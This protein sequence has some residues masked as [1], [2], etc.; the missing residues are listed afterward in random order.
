MQNKYCA[1]TVISFSPASVWLS[2]LI[3]AACQLCQLICSQKIQLSLSQM[4]SHWRKQE[5][6]LKTTELT[7]KDSSAT[8]VVNTRQSLKPSSCFFCRCRWRNAALFIAWCH[9]LGYHNDSKIASL[10]INPNLPLL[11]SSEF[12][13]CTVRSSML[14]LL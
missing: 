3:I 8:L 4:Q 1:Q 11:P 12:I 5:C 14:V 9:S 6:L 13:V 2:G 7:V 10:H